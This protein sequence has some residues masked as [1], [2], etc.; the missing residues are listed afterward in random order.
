M[1]LSFQQRLLDWFNAEKRD[2]PWRRTKD[3]YAIWVS[4]VMLQQTQVSTVI[5]YYERWMQRFPTVHALA[6]A[7]E[8]E[9]LSMWQGLG[10]Y[11]R[12]R[13]LHEGARFASTNGMPVSSAEWLKVPGVGRYTAGAISSIA[14]SQATPLV[15]GNVERVYARLTGDR[16]PGKELESAAWRWAST[17]VPVASP[18]DWNQAIMELG[19]CICKPA[20]PVC[21]R[22]PVR[23]DC[24]AFAQRSQAELP[25]KTAKPQ[26]VQLS[27][28]VWIPYNQGSFG[29]SQIEIGEWWQGMWQFPR[30]NSDSE[31]RLIVGSGGLE[32]AG[33]FTYH[34]THHRIR[35]QAFVHRSDR[36]AEAL[37]WL[38]ETDL[39]ALPM[40]SPQRKALRLAIARMENP[41]LV[42][43]E[44]A[45]R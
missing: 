14:L 18:G 2:L 29:L 36:R 41:A 33:A 37:T 3:P 7:E 23:D 42:L 22:C 27:E 20:S 30:G 34:V 32:H 17:M 25:V 12:C 15:D 21:T 10:Y 35:M 39:T 11:R 26:T 16:S 4:E 5:P 6:I 28:I 45:P 24:E 43:E 9:V 38:A 44:V 19:A 1:A 13:L 31:L 8:Q 40:P